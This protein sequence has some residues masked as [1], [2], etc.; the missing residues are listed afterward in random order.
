[1]K[2]IDYHDFCKCFSKFI[3]YSRDQF[4]S[5]SYIVLAATEK[6]VSHQIDYETKQALSKQCKEQSN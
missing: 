4:L 2:D 3:Y 6:Q 1:M 5:L